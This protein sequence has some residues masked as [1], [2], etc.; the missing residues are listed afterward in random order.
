MKAISISAAWDETRALLARDG[1]L[2]ASVALALIVLPAVIAGVLDP[3]APGEV[4]APMWFDA[5]VMIISLIS[6]AGQLALVRLALGPSIT[7]AGAISHGLRRFPPYFLGL[8]ILGLGMILVAIPFGIAAVALGL[9]LEQGSAAALTGPILILIFLMA[10]AVLF[11]AVRFLMAMPVASAEI[12]GTTEILKRSWHLT[13]GNWLKL[14]L[15]LLLFVFAAVMII[16]AVSLVA[17]S[18]ILLA[19]KSIEPMSTAA[20]LGALIEGVF[21]GMFSVVF[22]L[23][24]TRIYVQLSGR[25]TV[26]AAA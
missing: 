14:F 3:R 22:T 20:L 1:K 12:S 13:E 7:V 5:V 21:S 15:F 10:M 9:D 26:E 24:L 2:F 6:I 23:M 11:V 17:G 25:E 4:D 19:F 8:L 18:L 16:G